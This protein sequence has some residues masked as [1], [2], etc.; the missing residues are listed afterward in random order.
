MGT[1]AIATAIAATPATAF[2][3]DTVTWDHI[4][5]ATGVKVYVAEYGDIISVCD[6]SANG[7]AAR[8]TITDDT[9]G[10]TYYSITASGGAGTCVTHRASDGA[11]YDLIEGSKITI[12]YDG[13]GGAYASTG[14]VND[15]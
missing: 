6:T 1:L 4:W 5:T 7:H 11:S 9:I 2:A 13:N 15:H 8:A 10:F 3:A 14:Y 12:S